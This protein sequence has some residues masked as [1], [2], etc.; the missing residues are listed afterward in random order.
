MSIEM[1]TP[2]PETCELRNRV[3][4]DNLEIIDNVM[5]GLSKR[6]PRHINDDDIRSAASCAMVMVAGESLEDPRVDLVRNTYWLTQNF[7]KQ[8][9]LVYRQD[10]LARKERQLEELPATSCE[11]DQSRVEDR[12]LAAK[13]LL[14]MR[15]PERK[16]VW[17]SVM[18][19]VPQAALAGELGL[20]RK[21]TTD[22]VYRGMKR[23]REALCDEC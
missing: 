21:S 1:T 15:K 23:A 3:V 22:R 8:D 11:G 7:L 13:A 5:K 18:Q 17:R 12:E 20:T 4:L 6:M 14:A 9:R 2:V 19:G 10:R 16:A